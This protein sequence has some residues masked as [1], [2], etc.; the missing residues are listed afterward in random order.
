[1]TVITREY[2]PHTAVQLSKVRSE[3]ENPPLHGS[4]SRSDKALM[5]QKSVHST[6]Y[7]DR[8]DS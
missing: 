2:W 5:A 1:L 7:G 3:P 8:F 4:C 6:V